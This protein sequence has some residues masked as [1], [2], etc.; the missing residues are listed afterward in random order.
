MI[1][2]YRELIVSSAFIVAFFGYL[3]SIISLDEKSIRKEFYRAL[4][5]L[6]FLVGAS[7]ITIAVHP[8]TGNTAVLLE[9]PRWAPLVA[10]LITA[11]TLPTLTK[12]WTTTGRNPRRR[13]NYEPLAAFKTLR[14]ERITLRRIVHWEREAVMD[15]GPAVKRL[16]W[17]KLI[18]E[19]LNRRDPEGMDAARLDQARNSTNKETLL[20]KMRKLDP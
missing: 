3:A 16:R 10:V 19:L 7:L 20:E 14:D 17:V 2:E 4:V 1:S 13:P 9:L 11:T 18:R 5:A 8:D 15:S 12:A 6:T